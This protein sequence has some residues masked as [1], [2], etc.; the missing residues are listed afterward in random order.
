[1]SRSDQ[2]EDLRGVKACRYLPV[3]PGM[4]FMID[5]RFTCRPHDEYWEHESRRWEESNRAYQWDERMRA[6][7]WMRG[8]ER[9]RAWE[10][11]GE[12]NYNKK[13]R[14]RKDKVTSRR[15]RPESSS[16]S[17]VEA[18][19]FLSIASQKRRFFPPFSPLFDVLWGII[20]IRCQCTDPIWDH[21]VGWVRFVW[22]RC[23]R[24]DERAFAWSSDCDEMI[25][26]HYEK[27]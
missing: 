15:T 27:R 11:R 20:S 17:R 10:L 14:R 5:K 23:M 13:S 25:W 3:T 26:S 8:E 16:C 22:V 4:W 21:S 24:W 7:S 18:E 1:M 2:V 6:E 19:T 12:Q 9:M